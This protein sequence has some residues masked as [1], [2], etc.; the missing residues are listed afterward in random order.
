MEFSDYVRLFKRRV[1]VVLLPLLLCPLAAYWSADRQPRIYSAA[2]EVLLKP[3]NSAEEISAV[4]SGGSGDLYDPDRYVGSQ[5]S[6][7]GSR[8]L[9]EQLASTRGQG[10]DPDDL[11]GGLS[12]SQKGETNVLV[13]N[14]VDVD[15]ARAADLANA[16]AIAYIENRRLDQVA[17]LSRAEKELAQDVADLEATL[18]DLSQQLAQQPEGSADR[19]LLET[20]LAS[21]ERQFQTSNDRLGEI[22]I[23]INLKRGEAELVE[24][25]TEPWAPFSP[26]PRRSAMLGLVIGGLLG[27]GAALMLERFDDRLRGR[28][29]FEQASGLNVIG[30]LAKDKRSSS[31]PT[32][33]AAINN[34]TG[35]LAESV[36]QLATSLRFFGVDQPLKSLLITSADVGDGKSLVSTNLAVAFAQAGVRTVLVSGDLRRPRLE[37]TFAIPGGVPGVTEIVTTVALH[38]Q[39][40]GLSYDDPAMVA[41]IRRRLESVL[42]PRL[43]VPGLY[44]LSSGQQPPN[45][46]EILGSPACA[47]VL[48]VLKNDFA[49]IVVIDSPPVLAVADALIMSRHADATVVVA[50]AGQTRKQHLTN[51]LEALEPSPTRVLGIGLNKS[52]FGREYRYE[53]ISEGFLARQRSTR[54]ANPPA[55]ETEPVRSRASTATVSRSTA[56]ADPTPVQSTPSSN[57]RTP[58]R[59]ETESVEA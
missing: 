45:P 55:V 10:E 57:G 25:A 33:I 29:E 18:T 30:E 59:L 43:Q 23:N 17:G 40:T 50:S 11:G 41:F 13:V 49:D 42:V 14:Y 16:F 32:H 6:V 20:R 3:N 53:P 7:L 36:R 39:R 8:Q 51:A 2:A 26:T 19:R 27:V 48:N 28:R 35:A 4:G 47:A 31:D 5:I 22:R 52:G 12:G 34:P 44:L 9:A 38:S 37:S 15:P 21:A 54:R 24:R 1:F 56:E 46:A 58:D